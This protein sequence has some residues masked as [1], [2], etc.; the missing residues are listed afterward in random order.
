[1]AT[2]LTKKKDTTGAPSSGDLTNS[3]GGAELAVNTADKRLYTKDSG[4]SVVEVGINPT[5][6]TTG[7]LN[8]S[9]AVVFNDAGADV[10]FRV[11]SDTDANAFFLEGSSGNVGIGTPSPAVSGLEISR[12]TGTASPTPAE[13]RISTTSNASDW[14]ATNPWGRISFYSADASSGGAG[15]HAAIQTV[16][17][18]STGGVSRLEFLVSDSA[19]KTLF[20]TLSFEPVGTNTTQTL[21]FS[22]SGTERMRIDSSGNVLIGTTS[23]P[24]GGITTRLAVTQSAADYS[25]VLN[26]TNATPYG[27]YIKHNTDSNGTGNAFI[28]AAGNAADRFVVRSNG[29]IANYTAND[30]NLSDRREKTNFAPAKSYLQTICA[31]PVQTFNYI[32]QNHE[33]DPGLTL[34]V[35]AQDVQAVAPELVMESNWAAKDEEPKMRLSVYQTDLQYALMKS[36]QELKAELDTVK[37]ELATLKGN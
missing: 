5:S 6:I 17:T 19:N 31:I 15:L 29:G 32:D 35:V 8:T 13:L 22:G 1:M 33:E 23:Q 12:A 27:I 36:I 3:S 4:G 2:I 37:A 24:V 34:G 28:V 30:V 14:S 9:G 7:T 18:S 11:E 26:N 20:K 16:A 21:F 10:D 25:Q